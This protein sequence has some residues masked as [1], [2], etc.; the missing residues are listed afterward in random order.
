MCP[1]RAL[2]LILFGFAISS[3]F[4]I[5]QNKPSIRAGSKVYVASMPDG[6][7]AYLKAAL[8]K[9]K[10]ALTMVASRE[11]AEFEI[12]GSSETQKAGAAK[13][14]IRLNW[15]SSEQA[16]ISIADLK[17]GEV[18][19]AY[20]VNKESSAHGKQ[21]TAEACAKHMKEILTTK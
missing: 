8:E 4:L 12:V 21:S 20:S 10:V 11:E 14:I 17:T 3:T 2:A 5:A 18:V 9:K 13:K 15:H 1:R 6:F 16:S 19:F 7:D